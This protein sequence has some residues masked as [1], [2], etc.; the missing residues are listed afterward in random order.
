M[1]SSNIFYAC[2]QSSTICNVWNVLYVLKLWLINSIF[3]D[4]ESYILR[5][6]LTVICLRSATATLFYGLMH[7]CA[8]THTYIQTNIY[9]LSK[10]RKP[11]SIEAHYFTFSYIHTFI[12]THILPLS[13]YTKPQ[14]VMAHWFTVSYIHTCIH[15][16]M[17]TCIHTHMHTHTHTHT[18]S[19]YI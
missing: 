18:L 19:L 10:R 11:Q 13:L 12:H 16:Y 14:S 2:T 8:Q 1:N 4:Y 7:T 5:S 6:D 3:Y 17:H 15:A 9:S